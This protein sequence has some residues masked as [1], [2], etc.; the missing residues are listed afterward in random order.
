[1]LWHF[2]AENAA[3]RLCRDAFHNGECG[4]TSVPRRIQEG[5]EEK[6][7]LLRKALRAAIQLH[8]ERD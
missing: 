3:L 7:Q 8:F 5:M 1:M 2:I 6:T 4:A